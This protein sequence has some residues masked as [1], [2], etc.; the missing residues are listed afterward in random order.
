MEG[1]IYPMLRKTTFAVT[2]TT[3][4]ASTAFAGIRITCRDGATRRGRPDGDARQH[5]R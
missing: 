3:V 1:L 5:I 4:L 2:L